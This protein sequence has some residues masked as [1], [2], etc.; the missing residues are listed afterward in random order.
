MLDAVAVVAEDG[1]PGVRP[2]RESHTLPDLGEHLPGMEG[3]P[4]SPPATDPSADTSAHTLVFGEGE[5]QDS[6]V[7][8]VNQR[9]EGS[10]ETEPPARDESPN[11][12][13]KTTLLA[14]PKSEHQGGTAHIDKPRHT[15][16]VDA[17]MPDE[18]AEA[19]KTQLRGSFRPPLEAPQIPNVESSQPEPG[20]AVIGSE[21]TTAGTAVIGSESTTAGTAVIGS[22]PTDGGTAVIGSES[23]IGETAVIG[24]ESKA[25]GTAVIGSESKAG[26]TAVIGSES[27]AGADSKSAETRTSA[28]RSEFATR[29][30]SVPGDTSRQPPPVDTRVLEEPGWPVERP[31]PITGSLSTTSVPEVPVVGNEF[32]PPGPAQAVPTK[33]NNVAIVSGAVVFLL[34]GLAGYFIWWFMSGGGHRSTVRPEVV[35]P[36]VEIV[37]PAP[38]PPIPVAPEGMVLVASGFYPIGRTQ[39]AGRVETSEIDTPQHMVELKAFYI[40]RTEVTNAQYKAFVDQTGHAPPKKGWVAG[41]FPAEQENWPVVWVSWQD[42]V[43]YATWAGKRLPTENEWE[44]AARGSDGRMYPW[45]DEWQPGRANI[46]SKRIVDVGSHPEGA[47]PSGALD[48]IGNVWEWT[49]DEFALYPGTVAREPKLDEGITYRV[50]RGGAYD[51]DRKHDVAYRGYVA[52]GVGYEK[53]GFRCVKSAP[54]TVK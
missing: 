35:N 42:A 17:R 9:V 19:G 16:P 34:L 24:S 31:L 25:S 26:G 7:S 18:T 10:G 28:I 38:P 1:Q 21:S 46:V 3:Q 45:G 37:E 52:V 30:S 43:D 41:T 13:V 51:G 27:N 36:P 47:S 22:K 23:T 48:M 40:D 29:P 50:I 39:L 8:P 44:A 14:G 32:L 15:A 4:K 6:I 11:T 5:S 20:T 33:K 49:A 12:G 2:P 53:T 54:A